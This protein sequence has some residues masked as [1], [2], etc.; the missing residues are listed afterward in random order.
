MRKV[1]ILTPFRFKQFEPQLFGINISRNLEIYENSSLD[2]NWDMV[3]VYEDIQELKKIKC[4]SGGLIF[5]SGEP[6]ESRN[7]CKQFLEQ[8]DVIVTSQTR[9]NHKKIILYQQSLPW[10]F[11]L[12]HNKQIFKY[13]YQGLYNLKVPK[14][15]S[16]I[17]LISSN[18]KMMPGHKKR[19]RFMREIKRTFGNQIDIFGHGHNEIICKDDGILPYKFHICIENSSHDNYWTE[20][21]ADSYLGYSVPIYYGCTNIESYFSSN[22]MEKID[23]N[24]IS[25]SLDLIQNII[26]NMD[27][28]YESKFDQML[29]SRKRVLEEFNL[30]RFMDKLIEEKSVSLGEQKRITL[31]PKNHLFNQKITDVKLRIRRKFFL[32]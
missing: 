2:L 25:K 18:K 8:F 31:I 13:D 9:L 17:S 5:I 15:K 27:E 28:L 1:N 19:L 20:K 23:I 26:L 6:E 16:K 12:D 24:N 32:K 21:I 11:S 10:H 14:K 7:Y 4:S 3:V 29:T 22:S 30:Y